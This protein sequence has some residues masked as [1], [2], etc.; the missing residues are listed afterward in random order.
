MDPLYEG[1]AIPGDNPYNESRAVPGAPSV[2]ARKIWTAAYIFWSM[3]IPARMQLPIYNTMD[4]VAYQ[5]PP[6]PHSPGVSGYQANAPRPS[7]QGD[8][9]L[10]SLK[11]PRF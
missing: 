11:A 3:P 7:N 1:W 9:S 5:A 6:V 4:L 10:M 8:I 2:F